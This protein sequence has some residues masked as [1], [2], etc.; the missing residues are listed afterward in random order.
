[1]IGINVYIHLLM[2]K[3]MIISQREKKFMVKNMVDW[4]GN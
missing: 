2:I 1:M 4:L 3:N